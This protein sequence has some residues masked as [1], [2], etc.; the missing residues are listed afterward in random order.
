MQELITH[1]EFKGTSVPKDAAQPDSVRLTERVKS[2]ALYLFTI[3]AGMTIAVSEYAHYNAEFLQQLENF[4]GNQQAHF[5]IDYVA[6]SLHSLE[7]GALIA[8]AIH[9]LKSMANNKSFGVDLALGGLAT[10][11]VSANLANAPEALNDTLDIFISKALP[12][13][14]VVPTLA[15]CIL[16]AAQNTG[17]K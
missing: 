13:Y 1:Q 11:V 17:D 14:V 10:S 7:V 15:Y 16:K 5:I 8:S 12:L 6:N 9:L 3:L 4:L 2:D